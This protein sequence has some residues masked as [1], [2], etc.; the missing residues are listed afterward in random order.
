MDCAIETVDLRKDFPKIKSYSEIILHP[1]RIQRIKVLKGIDLRVDHGEIFGLLGPNGA[2]KTT[3]IKILCTLVLPSLG[4]ARVNGLDIAQDPE[5]IRT[6][7]GLVSSDERSFYWRLTPRQNLCFFGALYGFQP[8]EANRRVEDL[9]DLLDLS[10]FIDKPFRDCSSGMKQRIAIARAL[11]TDPD[12]LFMDEPTRTLDPVGAGV[13]RRFIR[14]RIAGEEGKTIFLA[15]HI[16]SE[17]EELCDRVGIIDQG[18][19]VAC[20]DVEALRAHVTVTSVIR[21]RLS[22]ISASDLDDL[23]TVDG[24]A[25]VRRLA[26]EEDS[27]EVEIETSERRTALGRLLERLVRIGARVEDIQIREPSLEEI[28]CTLTGGDMAPREP[29][30]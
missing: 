1:T 8:S 20:G 12:I 17:A 23:A 19:L 16:M 6:M 29:G 14:N 9:I 3:L 30:K 13:L 27:A 11:M 26:V 4:S 5:K 22:G 24:V 28:F 7:I 2:G 15:T 10:D 18:L 25:G 21:L